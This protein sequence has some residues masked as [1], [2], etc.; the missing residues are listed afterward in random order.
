MNDDTAQR[1]ALADKIRSDHKRRGNKLRTTLA[2]VTSLCVVAGVVGFAW[3]QLNPATDDVDAPP[4][5]A[6]AP[7]HATA[8]YGFELTQ[9]LLTGNE[10][11]STAALSVGLYEDFLCGTC[12]IFHDETG[13]Y[14]SEQ[15]ELGAISLTYYPFSFLLNQSTDEYS[16][17]AANAAACVADQSGV[18]SYAKMHDLLLEHQPAQGGAGLTDEKLIEFAADAGA[19]D[20]SEC[21]TERTFTPWVEEAMNAAIQADVSET[22]TVRVNGVNVVKVSGDRTTMPGTAELQYAIEALQ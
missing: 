7:Q 16:Q 12:S 1:Q 17:R 21:I 15:V 13:G 9:A 14:L 2:V 11:A 5:S 10:N 19:T 22:P 8:E 6:T 18:V 20:A 3:M 4:A